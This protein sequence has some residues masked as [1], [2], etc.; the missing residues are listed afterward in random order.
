[1]L[2]LISFDSIEEKEAMINYNFASGFKSGSK[3]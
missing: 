1:M 2:R 3:N